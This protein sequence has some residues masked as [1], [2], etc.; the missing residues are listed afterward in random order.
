VTT[1]S[2]LDT[3]LSQRTEERV[4][5]KTMILAAAALFLQSELLAQGY[6]G[7]AA[8]TEPMMLIDKPTAGLL[9]RGSYLLHTNLFQHGGVV[10]GVAVGLFEQFTF[11]IS[12]GGTNIIGPDKIEMNP[13]PGVQVKLRIIDEST[14]SPA[15]AIGF[16]SQGK[17]P[18]VDSLSR[19]TIKSPGFYVV[20]SKN[21]ELMGNLSIHGGL[22]YTT[23]RQDGDKDLNL[24]LGFEK[25]LAK[26]LSILGEYDF[27]INDNLQ[28]GQG[29]GYM[30]FGVRWGAGKGLIVGL[31]L[32]NVTK[33]QKNV[34]VG[35]RTVQIDFVSSF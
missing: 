16:D 30:N 31:D 17:E 4:N 33:N 8:T 7:S 1:I 35:N 22:N 11:G 9:K 21:Y 23:E 13:L 14:L 10:F 12:Y 29:R 5:K 19:F 15:I 3:Q 18:Y 28:M 26:D 32:K 25:S 24:Y 2:E 6:A 20:G 34:N 27:A